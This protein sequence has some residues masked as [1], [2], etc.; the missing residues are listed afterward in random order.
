ML[1]R[2]VDKFI[3]KKVANLFSYLRKVGRRSERVYYT[4][5]QDWLVYISRRTHDSS[6]KITMGLLFGCSFH[7]VLSFQTF[8]FY[9]VSFTHTTVSDLEYMLIQY[10]KTHQFIERDPS[11]IFVNVVLEPK[12]HDDLI[13]SE[14][15]DQ[16]DK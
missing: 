1:F 11:E 14:M 6:V 13:Y 16:R 10:N 2:I 4:A 3:D 12:G 7:L 5:Y 9:F 8:F 15:K